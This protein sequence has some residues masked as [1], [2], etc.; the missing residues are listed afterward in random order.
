MSSPEHRRQ[1]SELPEQVTVG[2]DRLVSK[3]LEKQMGDYS[4]ALRMAARDVM[5]SANPAMPQPELIALALKTVK[6]KADYLLSREQQ[7][8]S[9]K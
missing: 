2:I 1:Q 4:G 8:N 7:R 9:K 5:K 6:E 3:L